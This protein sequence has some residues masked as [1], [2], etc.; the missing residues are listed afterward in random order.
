MLSLTLSARSSRVVV[1]PVAG[2]A[3]E[4]DLEAGVAGLFERVQQQLVDALV[5]GE[6][7]D[8][9]VGRERQ[10][11]HGQQ[12]LTRDV[13]VHRA[14]AGQLRQ[15]DVG[16]RARE[17]AR[18]RLARI[19]FVL[20]SQQLEGHDPLEVVEDRLAGDDDRFGLVLSPDESD[21]LL[22]RPGIGRGSG[23]DEGGWGPGPR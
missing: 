13:D 3:V 16:D 19:L 11:P 23:K 10:R 12:E 20:R 6:L 5:G 1:G 17:H 7:E 15:P 14:R 4:G 18:R 9:A 22:H 21:A 8:H 2:E